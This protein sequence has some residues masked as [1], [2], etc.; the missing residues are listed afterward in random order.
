MHH[1]HEHRGTDLREPRP[2]KSCAGVSYTAW[3]EGSAWVE[4]RVPSSLELNEA[5]EGQEEENDHE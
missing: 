3:R 4:R 2:S 1:H 5:R